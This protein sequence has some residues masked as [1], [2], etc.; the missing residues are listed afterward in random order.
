MVGSNGFLV[1]AASTHE[2]RYSSPSTNESIFVPILAPGTLFG[3]CKRQDPLSI[4][5]TSAPHNQCL[6]PFLR[7]SRDHAGGSRLARLRDT[8]KISE[9]QLPN[10]VLPSQIEYPMFISNTEDLESCSVPACLR[11]VVVPT[12]YTMLDMALNRHRSLQNPSYDRRRSSRP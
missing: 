12:D 9:G 11:L 5:S 2:S 4:G 3:M 6:T 10:T 8:M 7:C 1:G